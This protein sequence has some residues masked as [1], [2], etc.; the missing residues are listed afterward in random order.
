VSLSW[1]EQVTI[2]LSPQQVTMVRC[3]RGLRPA[4]KD[5]KA[6]ACPAP[7]DGENW[8]PAIEVLRDAL[9]HPNIEAADATVVLSNHFVRYLL[10]PWNPDLVTAQEELAFARA[11]FVQAFGGAAQDWVLK[12]S[13]ARPGAPSVACAL[14]RPL[15]Q[16]VTALIA[17]SPLRLRSLQPSLMAVC[18]ERDR[19][20]AG[21]AWIAIAES[22]RLLLG[23]LRAGEWVSLR[24]RPLNGHAVVLVEIIEQ[25][26]LLL[27]IEPGNGKI[28]LHRTG[29]AALDLHG[30]KVHDWLSP[31]AAQQAGRAG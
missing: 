30:L 6:L 14:E 22:G 5:R 21:D 11:R 2:A 18:N 17:G 24:S 23:A 25:E 4:L 16:V 20:P 13:P 27:D 8:Q 15:L 28:Y 7:V 29:E 19:L 3:S 26:A 9:T 12:L 1:R 31:G 10:L